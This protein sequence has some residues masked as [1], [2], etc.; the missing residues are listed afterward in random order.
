MTDKEVVMSQNV[1]S[2]SYNTDESVN[3]FNLLLQNSLS[4]PDN[5]LSYFEEAPN[6]APTNDNESSEESAEVVETQTQSNREQPTEM[7]SGVGRTSPVPLNTFDL[8]QLMRESLKNTHKT[9]QASIKELL[10]KK[11][12]ELTQKEKD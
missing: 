12:V 4:S 8:F 1:G 5:P 6:E 2:N 9:T 7:S 11:M 3:F 10:D